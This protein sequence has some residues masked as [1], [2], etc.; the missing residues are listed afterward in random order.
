MSPY[1]T[2]TT[3]A[4]AWREQDGIIY[5]LI[6]S[7]GTTGPEWIRR[8][9]NN[10][11]G[12]CDW[13]K[14]VLHSSDLKTTSRVTTEIA[15]L[16][17]TFFA[18]GDLTTRK[19]HAEAKRRKLIL[20]N[21][22]VT[23]LIRETFSDEEMEAMNLCRIVVMHAPLKN[24]VS[25]PSILCVCRRGDGRWLGIDCDFPGSRWDRGDGF[26]FVVRPASFL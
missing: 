10:G 11:F 6:T 9:E 21:A 25:G 15:I 2:D 4:R 22:E 8:L 12:V 1:R 17:G 20:P 14:C 19:I 3:P 7:D 16:K 13:A 18:D 5:F 23:G 24:S 26:A